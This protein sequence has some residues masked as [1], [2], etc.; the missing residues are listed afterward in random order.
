MK[1]FTDYDLLMVYL[2]ECEDKHLEQQILSS[3]EACERLK[4]LENEMSTIDNVIDSNTTD[5]EYGHQLWNK[6]SG[7]LEQVEKY[8]WLDRLKNLMFI[9]QFSLASVAAVF[10]ASLTFYMLGSYSNKSINSIENNN[11]ASQLL[12][13]NVQYHLTQTDHFLTQVSNMP[14]QSQTPMMI[15]TAKH[16]LSSNR[17]YKTALNN[18]PENQTDNKKLSQLLVELDQVLTEM[19]NSSPNQKQEQLYQY[20]QDQLLYKVKTFNQQLKTDNTLI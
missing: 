10:A 3:S 12:A 11:Y 9:P 4:Q 19:S 5:D 14:E 1:P 13:Q 6:I 17:I 8:T 16:L 20:T 7:Q 18:S 15:S 2:N